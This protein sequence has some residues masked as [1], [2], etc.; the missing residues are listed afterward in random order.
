M[1]GN[2]GNYGSFGANGNFGANAYGYGGNMGSGMA[3][4]MGSAMWI[5]LLVLAL[6]V[7][8]GV[9]AV[10]MTSKKKKPATPCASVNCGAHGA[11]SVVTG[12]CVCT[13]GYSGANCQVPPNGPPPNGA[14]GSVTCGAHGTCSSAT[15]DCVCVDGYAGANCQVPPQTN[16]CAGVDCGHGSCSEATGACVCALGWQGAE[17]TTPDVG[18][19]ANPLGATS[20]QT[21]CADGYIA[22]W[23]GNDASYTCVPASSYQFNWDAAPDG[24]ELTL[25]NPW[26]AKANPCYASGAP[27]IPA[28][29]TALAWQMIGTSQTTCYTFPTNERALVADDNPAIG[30]TAN[31]Y[32]FNTTAKAGYALDAS[33]AD[34]GSYEIVGPVLPAPNPVQSPQGISQCA[35][36]QIAVI[37]SVN[38]QNAYVCTPGNQFMLLNEDDKTIALTPTP[39]IAASPC[40][41]SDFTQG[42]AVPVPRYDNGTGGSMTNCYGFWDNQWALVNFDFNNNPL[43]PG[44]YFPQRWNG[45]D[46]YTFQTSIASDDVYHVSK[47]PPT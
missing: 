22:L 11:C 6:V 30:A 32:A 12:Q 17:C 31:L 1:Y 7:V 37:Q 20:S 4:G 3:S 35:P 18:P 44:Q 19:F 5:G 47:P 41:L 40:A 42:P 34:M 25:L 13:D 8:G 23:T 9:V 38:A 33:R 46:S 14:C 43:P 2:Y 29:T 21:V 39:S 24:T 16:P 45:V 10:V 28:G 27:S 15:G 36:G 26:L